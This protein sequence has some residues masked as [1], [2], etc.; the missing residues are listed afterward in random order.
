M[1]WRSGRRRKALLQLLGGKMSAKHIRTTYM[2]QFS[3]LE[4]YTNL[5]S[6]AILASYVAQAL[7]AIGIGH[8]LLSL[9]VSGLSIFLAAFCMTFV[10]T[11]LRALNNIVHECCHMTFSNTRKANTI[12]G[13]LAAS[14]ILSCFEDYKQEHMTHHMHLGD[15][16]KDKDLQSIEDLGLHDP[17]TPHT[18]LR[19]IMT[20][21]LGRHLPYYLGANFS[22]RD[23]KGYLV[24]KV[25]LVLAILI[26]LV[27]APMTIF[28]F[29]LFP[30][31]VL[32]SA[33]N[34]WTDCM[35][36]AGLVASNDDLDASRNVLASGIVRLLFFPR[37]DCFHLVHHLFP[38][39]PARHLERCHAVL[40]GDEDYRSRRHA[41]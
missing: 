13:S 37:N 19:H 4:R 14:L 39:V 24:L 26:A 22:K 29:I 15:Y 23:G 20:P 34:Y 5:Q 38:Q 1:F 2:S 7:I 12:V 3:R 18:V 41:C 9:P 10:G 30:Y 16:D 28:L 6:G 32:F 35:D 21:F 11:R 31:V 25:G 33:M 36:H 17:L 8:I 27:L 40:K